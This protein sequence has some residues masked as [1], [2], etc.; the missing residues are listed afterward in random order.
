M[1]DKYLVKNY[2][3][4]ICEAVKYLHAHNYMHRDIKVFYL[5]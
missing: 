3:K 5:F 1:L 2:F 4:N